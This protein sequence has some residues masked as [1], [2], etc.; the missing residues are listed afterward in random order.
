MFQPKLLVAAPKLLGMSM[1]NVYIPYVALLPKKSFRYS[2]H[3]YFVHN[4][5]PCVYDYVIRGYWPGFFF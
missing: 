2:V 3:V 1:Y 4:Y 5:Y